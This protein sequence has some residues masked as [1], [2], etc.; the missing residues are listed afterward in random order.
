MIDLS[1]ISNTYA[2]VFQGICTR[3]IVTADDKTTLKKAAEDSTSTPSVV[4]G[5]IEGGIEK[6]VSK[7]DTPDHRDGAILQFWG[8]INSGKPLQYFLQSFEK[9]LSYKI[10]QDI[11]VKPFTAVFNALNNGQGKMDMMERIGHCGDGFEWTENRYG[12]ELIIVPLM[13]PDFIIERFLGYKQGI[14]G[15]NFWVM[16]ETKKAVHQ[17]NENV[18]RAINE[19]EGVITPFDLCSAGSKPETNF[20]LI[21][22]TTNHPYCSS[23]K[24]RIGSKSKVPKNVKYIPEIVINGL[25][26][27]VTKKA[28]RIGILAALNIDG[29]KGISAGNYGGTLGKYKINLLELFT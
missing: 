8:A 23:L 9:E 27:E 24:K 7:S 28:M 11:L 5:R 21:G 10:R 16:C 6:W 22:P 20:P 19:I 3:V 1:R 17:V 25:S 12:K 4:I 13:V 26:L 2:E 18:L 15:A 29:V 14:M